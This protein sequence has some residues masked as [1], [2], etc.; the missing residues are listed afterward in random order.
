MSKQRPLRPPGAVKENEFI[1]RCIKCSKCAQVCP[2]DSITIFHLEAGRHFGTPGIMARETPCYLCMECPS[3]CPSGALDNTLTDMR[4]VRMGL[5]VIDKDKCLPYMGVICRSCFDKCPLYREAITLE[6]ER[7]P[8]VMKEHCTGCG[9]C[10]H[11]CPAEEVAI[12]VQPRASLKESV[13]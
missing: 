8:V 12:R 9:I 1:Q 13:G 3:V 5:A 2:Y 4:K 11:V 10:E 6:D 7:Y